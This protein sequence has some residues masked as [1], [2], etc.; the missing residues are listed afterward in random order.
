MLRGAASVAL[1][2]LLHSNT[3]AQQ[4]N[5]FIYGDFEEPYSNCAF[6][7]AGIVQN[8][9]TGCYD[10]QNWPSCGGRWWA[11]QRQI[12]TTTTPGVQPVISV[13]SGAPTQTVPIPVSGNRMIRYYTNA[14]CPSGTYSM[15]MYQRLGA[16]LTAGVKYFMR[17]RFKSIKNANSDHRFRFEVVHGNDNGVPCTTIPGPSAADYPLPPSFMNYENQ[18]PNIPFL[19]GQAG[20]AFT[21]VGGENYVALRTTI[22]KG[23]PV[24]SASSLWLDDFELYNADLPIPPAMAQLN[25]EGPITQRTQESFGGPKDLTTEEAIDRTTN[26]YAIPNPTTG[27]LVLSTVGIPTNTPLL[28]L[29]SDGRLMRTHRTTGDIRTDIDLTDLP[30]GLYTVL[31]LSGDRNKVVRV[32]K[33]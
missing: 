15:V 13:H 18:T 27:P 23:N 10:A 20:F 19:D 21:A 29:A 33:E 28:V 4:P 14:S 31:V 3:Q 2:F 9:G 32:M 25:D 11:W 30:A 8:V 24:L 5:L 26:L 1:A 12:G 16:P 6:A 17:W 7:P 22:R